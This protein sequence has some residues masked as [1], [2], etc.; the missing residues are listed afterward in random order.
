MKKNKTDKNRKTPKST[1]TNEKQQKKTKN[2][3][4]IKNEKKK[5]KKHQD[6][7]TS[8]T[9]NIK[10]KHQ[11]RKT[12]KRRKKNI[13]RRKTKKRASFPV[14]P[15][16][17]MSRSPPSASDWTYTARRSRSLK[18]RDPSRPPL[19][20]PSDQAPALTAYVCFGERAPAATVARC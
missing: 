1:T 2:N 13:R 11:E 4:S 8:R 12:T 20:T 6:Q 18:P 5:K 19:A 17:A 3:E 16:S 14:L 7:K 15:T 9:K 10:N